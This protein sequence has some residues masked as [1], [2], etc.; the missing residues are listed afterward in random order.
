M[1]Q[2]RQ[3]EHLMGTACSRDG[4]DSATNIV[5]GVGILEDNI[6]NQGIDYRAHGLTIYE[7]DS[8]C[9]LTDGNEDAHE[10]LFCGSMPDEDG[11]PQITNSPLSQDFILDRTGLRNRQDA[12]A[13]VTNTVQHGENSTKKV[14]K[15]MRQR[16]S[17]LHAES[18]V[19]KTENFQQWLASA[20]DRLH[21]MREFLPSSA[22]RVALYNNFSQDFIQ[23]PKGDAGEFLDYLSYFLTDT[24]RNFWGSFNGAP[25]TFRDYLIM[26]GPTI[27][28]QDEYQPPL[29]KLSVEDI[30]HALMQAQINTLKKLGIP[31]VKIIDNVGS[32]DGSLNVQAITSLD[33]PNEDEDV[34]MGTLPRLTDINKDQLKVLWAKADSMKMGDQLFIDIDGVTLFL[35]VDAFKKPMVTQTGAFI[36]SSKTF[37]AHADRANAKLFGAEGDQPTFETKLSNVSRRYLFPDPGQSRHFTFNRVSGNSIET[38]QVAKITYPVPPQMTNMLPRVTAIEQAAHREVLNEIRGAIAARADRQEQLTNVIAYITSRPHNKRLNNGWCASLRQMATVRQNLI[39]VAHQQT[40]LDGRECQVRPVDGKCIN[41][42]RK[43]D[44]ELQKCTTRATMQEDLPKQ[45]CTKHAR[46]NVSGDKTRLLSMAEALLPDDQTEELREEVG[47]STPA[48]GVNAYLA[49]TILNGS[50]DI[51]QVDKRTLALPRLNP[52]QDVTNCPNWY[53]VEVYRDGEGNLYI[54]LPN[55]EKYYPCGL[56][57]DLDYELQDVEETQANFFLEGLVIQ[58]QNLIDVGINM[59]KPDSLYIPL[60]TVMYLEEVILDT[61]AGSCV[62]KLLDNQ[63][64]RQIIK[65]VGQY[66]KE[67]SHSLKFL[68]KFKGAFLTPTIHHETYTF[69]GWDQNQNKRMGKVKTTKNKLEETATTAGHIFLGYG[70]TSVVRPGLIVYNSGTKGAPVWENERIDRTTYGNAKH[71]PSL[72]DYIGGLSNAQILHALIMASMTVASDPEE[73]LD[74]DTGSDDDDDDEEG[75]DDLPDLLDDDD[76]DEEEDADLPDLDDDDDDDEEE[77]ADLPDLDDD[78]DDDFLSYEETKTSRYNKDN[79]PFVRLGSAISTILSDI[80]RVPISGDQHGSQAVNEFFSEFPQE[81]IRLIK[82]GVWDK[83]NSFRGNSGM[84]R[85]ILTTCAQLK[86]KYD[87]NLATKPITTDDYLAMNLTNFILEAFIEIG[88]H[89]ELDL[90]SLSK[91][92]ANIFGLV[93]Y[94]LEERRMNTI[95]AAIVCD[96]ELLQDHWAHWESSQIA[97]HSTENIISD[98]AEEEDSQYVFKRGRLKPREDNEG[99]LKTVFNSMEIEK[100]TPNVHLISSIRVP[101]SFPPGIGTAEANKAISVTEVHKRKYQFYQSLFDAVLFIDLQD[102]ATPDAFRDPKKRTVTRIKNLLMRKPKQISWVFNLWKKR[103]MS[104]EDVVFDSEEEWMVLFINTISDAI[105]RR[106]KTNASGIIRRNDDDDDDTSGPNSTKIAEYTSDIMIGF[107]RSLDGISD[108]RNRVDK[109]QRCLQF[110]IKSIAYSITNSIVFGLQTGMTSVFQNAIPICLTY[111]VQARAVEGLKSWGDRA[112]LEV[113]DF[114][115]NVYGRSVINDIPHAYICGGVSFDKQLTVVAH[116][117]GI[118]AVMLS[119]KGEVLCMG[120]FRGYHD[121]DA[122]NNVVQLRTNPSLVGN[123]R[124]EDACNDT[125]WIG[126]LTNNNFN[127][128]NQQYKKLKLL[129]LLIGSIF[130]SLSMENWTYFANRIRE[131]QEDLVN[132]VDI[133]NEAISTL[134]SSNIDAAAVLND[135]NNTITKKTERQMATLV[136]CTTDIHHQS[137]ILNLVSKQ[138]ELRNECISFL[139]T[140][141]NVDDFLMFDQP[142]AGMTAQPQQMM[143]QQKMMG[144]PQMTMVQ[145]AH[146]LGM[147]PEQLQQIVLA[148]QQ[149][150]PPQQQQPQQQSQTMDVQSRFTNFIQNVQQ[151]NDMVNGFIANPEFAN[152]NQAQLLSQIDTLE[153]EGQQLM[154]LGFGNDKKIALTKFLQLLEKLQHNLSNFS[155]QRSTRNRRGGTKSRKRRHRRRK[156]RRNKKKRKKKTIKRRRKK[157]RKTRRK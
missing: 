121:G 68:D 76:D 107:S 54:N 35:F 10:I 101:H 117:Q 46:S 105:K 143:G 93:K 57:S 25:L 108:V 50:H 42:Q 2:H 152:T 119:I 39:G 74:V 56:L 153:A 26:G 9:R 116:T 8:T 1:S 100:T 33:V 15:I 45:F 145:M 73:D 77:D 103:M 53:F 109:S 47:N 80:T 70:N 40:D 106:D 132:T 14:N 30:K 38:S 27:E 60:A 129:I 120:G 79:T 140:G 148:S 55:G 63:E 75:Y 96:E 41:I 51:Q 71:P 126:S 95:Q 98:D 104:D 97:S 16:V 130:K 99:L 90:R 146:N 22:A 154:N 127:L 72:R 66:V 23:Q 151:L 86:Q 89:N 149:Q 20:I 44:G 125:Y 36:T 34:G 85:L 29:Q 138:T 21:D 102:L 24:L 147:T 122:A 59:S 11:N 37:I 7:N 155:P 137:Y 4:P 48:L 135:F 13:V 43:R 115:N 58:G 82:N 94:W 17:A 111:C 19:Y 81:I 28:V 32:Q 3:L 114:V 142:Q 110:C 113:A 64:G 136:R 69:N 91:M 118:P 87:E 18:E 84:I 88:G 144:Q 134:H 67:N 78:G 65:D 131:N 150:Q 139:K 52:F 124:I 62:T 92:K 156:T 49:Q 123:L 112:P 6:S 133:L 128:P 61:I 83:L 12:A 5:S 141:R 157:G 31:L